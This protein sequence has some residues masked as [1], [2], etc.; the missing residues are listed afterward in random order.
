MINTYMTLI[1]TEANKVLS[2]NSQTLSTTQNCPTGWKTSPGY[3]F[4]LF[5]QVSLRWFLWSCK[6]V[7]K[8]KIL[9]IPGYGLGNQK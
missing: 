3:E 7:P 5:G 1:A 8:G 9:S 4:T 2:L 6:V